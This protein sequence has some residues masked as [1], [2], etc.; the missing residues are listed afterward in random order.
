MP[1]IEV[2]LRVKDCIDSRE[3]EREVE[4]GDQTGKLYSRIGRTR[5]VYRHRRV[6]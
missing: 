4:K 6:V 3:C 2:S 5:V 1:N